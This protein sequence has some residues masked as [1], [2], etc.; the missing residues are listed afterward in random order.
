MADNPIAQGIDALMT[1]A[2]DAADG[3]AIH[4][5]GIGLKQNSEAA[6][7]AD[8]TALQNAQTAHLATQR[9]LYSAQRSADDKGRAFI[10]NAAN[11]LGNFLGNTWSAAWTE[12][13]FPDQSTAVPGTIAGRRD[14]AIATQCT[15][16]SPLRAFFAL[17]RSATTVSINNCDA[18]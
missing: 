11:V 1:L 15:N 2:E 18:W 17:I 13:G 14:E 3:A 5:T 7:R 4:E 8:L 6:I 12:T 10:G 9:T 16:H